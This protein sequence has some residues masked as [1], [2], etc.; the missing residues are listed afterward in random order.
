MPTNTCTRWVTVS[1]KYL[2]PILW[3]AEGHDASVSCKFN[4]KDI[5]LSTH[6]HSNWS[7]NNY[8]NMIISCLTF[9]NVDINFDSLVRVL[10]NQKPTKYQGLADKTIIITAN[11]LTFLNFTSTECAVSKHL[12]VSLQYEN[13]LEKKV[14]VK[15]ACPPFRLQCIC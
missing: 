1:S 14:F 15:H 12:I 4:R 7:L 5:K 3:F 10:Q 2:V 9:Q 11:M 8:R 13:N 6:W